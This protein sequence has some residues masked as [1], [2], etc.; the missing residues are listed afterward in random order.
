LLAVD[1][2]AFDVGSG[3]NRFM[4]VYATQRSAQVDIVSA[5]FNSVSLNAEAQIDW[6]GLN[7]RVFH[8]PAPTVGSNLLRVN[9]ANASSRPAILVAC[10]NGVHQ[11]APISDITQQASAVEDDPLWTCVVPNGNSDKQVA[12]LVVATFVPGSSGA[13]AWT[14]PAAEHVDTVVG[15]ILHGTAG[16]RVGASGNTTIEVKL[17]YAGTTATAARGVA[18]NLNP[19]APEVP[20]EF[21]SRRSIRPRPFAPGESRF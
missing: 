17:T 1:E 16:S 3:E 11:S 9:Y 21:D 18:F 19:F 7:A 4:T 2:F 12:G 5:T 15:D 8:L 13:A 14:S 20:I 6:T 10:W